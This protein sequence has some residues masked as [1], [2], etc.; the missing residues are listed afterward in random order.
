MRRGGRRRLHFI[1]S[2]QTSLSAPHSEGPKIQSVTDC[3]CQAISRRGNS[4]P[5]KRRRPIDCLPIT[6]VK[7]WLPSC[8]ASACGA[9]RPHLRGESK[10]RSGQCTEM[11][12]NQVNLGVCGRTVAPSRDTFARGRATCGG[13]ARSVSQPAGGS[14]PPLPASQTESWC[15][16]RS[17]PLMPRSPAGRGET[18]WDGRGEGRFLRRVPIHPR[19]CAL[20]PH[21][22]RRRAWLH[23]APSVRLYVCTRFEFHSMAGTKDIAR[24]DEG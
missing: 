11:E 8:S 15:P 23:A 3:V 24:I 13:K 16:R 6:L 5:S 1:P 7:C 17:L 20:R 14:T 2:K 12:I 9:G 4:G 22:R 19:G 21:V 10:G 18:I